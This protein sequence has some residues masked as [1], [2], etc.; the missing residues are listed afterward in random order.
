MKVL[1]FG[2]V[3][4]SGCLVMKPRWREIEAENP[5]LETR[6]FEYDNS[7]EM[8]NK[9]KVGKHLPV[10]IFLDKNNNEITRLTGEPFKVELLKIINEHKDN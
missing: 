4:C 2:A 7:Q 5:W 1:K 8:V 10:F 9:W 6:Y 3:W